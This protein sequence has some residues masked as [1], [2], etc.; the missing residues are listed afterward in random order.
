MLDNVGKK[1]LIIYK[2]S[3]KFYNVYK[4]DAY[5]LNYLFGY[6]VLDKRKSG[7]PDSAITKVTNMLEE[8]KIS[9]QIIYDDKDP[10]VKNYRN[11]NCYEEYMKKAMNKIDIKE[12][13]EVLENK[14]KALD[15]EKLEKVIEAIE[16]CLE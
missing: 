8:K 15:N 4:D 12:R 11:L 2:N 13:M 6:K 16:A 3:G 14:I 9:Y 1:Y 5:I 7:F 10:F